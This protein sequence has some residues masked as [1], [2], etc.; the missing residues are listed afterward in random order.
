MWLF[1]AYLHWKGARR[2]APRPPARLGGGGGDQSSNDFIICYSVS[3]DSRLL[4]TVVGCRSAEEARLPPASSRR[5]LPPCSYQKSRTMPTPALLLLCSYATRQVPVGRASTSETSAIPQ[6]GGPAWRWQVAGGRWQVA[7]GRW[8]VE[9]SSHPTPPVYLDEEAE[10]I[11]APG[12]EL[13]DRGSWGRAP[14]RPG[15]GAP[16]LLQFPWEG[17][18][19]A[20]RILDP[21]NLGTVGA[22]FGVHNGSGPRTGSVRDHWPGWASSGAQ[23]PPALSILYTQTFPV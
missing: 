12:A 14:P 23:W 20:A 19:Y 21:P 1:K 10:E 13:L 8:Q 6:T 2:H 7:G 18:T 15:L 9:V 3:M 4:S 17:N 22:Q 11:A 5:R 16:R